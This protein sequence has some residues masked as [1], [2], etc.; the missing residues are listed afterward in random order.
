M[1][2][3]GSYNVGLFYEKNPTIYCEMGNSNFEVKNSNE[4]ARTAT[5][6]VVLLLDKGNNIVDID[7]IPTEEAFAAS[8]GQFIAFLKS[9]NVYAFLI[10]KDCIYLD[11]DEYI[12]INSVGDIE[13]LKI[14]SD[15]FEL[16]ATIDM[17]YTVKINDLE[18]NDMLL[19]HLEIIPKITK[20]E[21]K[22]NV[23][24]FRGC[25]DILKTNLSSY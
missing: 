13:Y 19:L 14:E 7:D 21:Q 1:I 22:T 24:L 5:S 16:E 6:N 10:N 23:Y 18:E 15:D 3:I 17:D 4:Y 2:Q 20:N 25:L 9:G 8:D 11:D 12:K